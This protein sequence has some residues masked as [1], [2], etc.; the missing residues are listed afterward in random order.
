MSSS[1]VTYFNFSDSNHPRESTAARLQEIRE[2]G[3]SCL[4][5]SQTKKAFGTKLLCKRKD[6]L[7]NQ[8]NYCDHHATA[9][10]TKIVTKI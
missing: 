1:F 4:T 9:T 10:V 5:C 7:V 2:T 8:Y 3:N 6:K